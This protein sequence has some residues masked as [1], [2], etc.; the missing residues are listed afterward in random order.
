MNKRRVGLWLL[1][2]TSA[3]LLSA[4]T[5]CAANRPPIVQ[6]TSSDGIDTAI[7]KA[8]SKGPGTTI[9]F[10]AGNYDHAR[11]T[12][13]NGI[14]L[15]GDGIGR[16]KL[17]F[18]I[19]FGSRSRVGGE[20]ESQGLTLGSTS[21]QTYFSLVSGARFTTFRWVRFRG[22]ASL[23]WNITDYT[24]LWRDAS[25]RN[26]AN[27]HDV[28]WTD[29]EF[30]STGDPQ[31]TTFNIW[32]DS[33]KGGGN[34]YNMTWKRCTFGVRNADGTFGSGRIGMLA[35]PSPPEHAADGP[36]PPT[37]S[38]PGG[39]QSTRPEFDFS[40]VTHGSGRAAQGGSR[41]YGFRL[42]DS[43]FV[44]P[45]TFTS[46]DI[47]DYIRAWAMVTYRLSSPNDVTG[48]MI[49]SAPDRVTTKGFDL[50]NV[51]MAG[52]FIREYGRDV[53]VS[54]VLASQGSSNYHV[55]PIVLTHDR[56]LYGL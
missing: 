17:N 39:I 25:V 47:C 48:T 52:K 28:V 55:R 54:H 37:E 18:A 5:A 40:Q 32:W 34:V 10:K 2:T 19:K 27:A 36:R 42:W 15:R 44:G 12:W 51:W 29:C 16:T 20:R 50:R 7:R 26:A 11:L 13:P 33:R 23:L 35:Q 30:E 22:R 41:G 49:R 56:Q 45:A 6:V 9:Y 3:F 43:S 46:L 14:N 53:A 24:A 21:E 8:I 4:A 31:G 38:D 1:L